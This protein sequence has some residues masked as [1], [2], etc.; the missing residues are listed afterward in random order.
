MGCRYCNFDGVCEV[1]DE[2]LDD[3]LGCDEFG[4][5]L[6]EDDEIPEDSCTNY[7]S[8]DDI[9]DD[10]IEDFDDEYGEDDI[11]GTED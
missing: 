8:E 6:C 10:D 1:F 9:E 5:C 3:G 4:N 11:P 2:N 7:V